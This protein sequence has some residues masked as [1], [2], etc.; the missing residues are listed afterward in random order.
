MVYEVKGKGR[1]CWRREDKN[2]R[3]Y[4]QGVYF[5]IREGRLLGQ[6]GK[7]IFYTLRNAFLYQIIFT[8]LTNLKSSI[9]LS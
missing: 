6:A 1:I 8:L 2:G 3:S 9:K 7:D 4:P 5:C